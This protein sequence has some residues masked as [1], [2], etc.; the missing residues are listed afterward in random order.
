MRK[1]ERNEERLPPCL[2]KRHGAYY[3]VRKGKWTRLGTDRRAV[4]I[5]YAKLTAPASGAM[6]KLIEE[7]R[8]AILHG[9]AP[10]TVRQY[11]YALNHM[12]FA[13]QDF[14]PAQVTQA[15]LY[16]MM[17]DLRG[18]PNM[19]N[20]VLTVARLVFKYAV[21]KRLIQNSPCVDVDR[22]PEKKRGRYI[23]DEELAAIRQHAGERLAVVIDLLYLT[24]SRVVDLLNLRLADITAEGLVFREEKT[25]KRRTVG[26]SADL[27]AA[28]EAA[29][30]IRGRVQGMTLLHGRWGGRVDYRS[31]HEQ[32]TRA[33]AAAGV[34]DAHI[35][36][37]R[38]K[39][40]TDAEAQGL[41][42]TRL[43]NHSSPAMTARYLRLRRA[44]VVKGPS[45]G[46]PID[47][48]A[49]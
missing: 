16:D 25:G 48:S 14:E 39:S 24:A 6:A 8:P 49:K 7:A 34:T 18:T 12:T 23:T 41:D 33:C 11:T 4:L 10:T 9:K 15:D 19:G 30:A 47:S 46:H 38:A 35:H 31:L 45:F 27:K 40:A 36:D 43:L 32:W 37:I 5:A 28:V 29:R 3:F 1:R 20:R 26:W 44:P 42:P 2:Y 22:H 13:L 17:D 21:K